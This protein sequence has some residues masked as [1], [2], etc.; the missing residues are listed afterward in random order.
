MR[1]TQFGRGLSLQ[2]LGRYADAVEDFD[3]AIIEGPVSWQRLWHRATCLSELDD[4]FR[5]SAVTDLWACL[6]MIEDEGLPEVS[7]LP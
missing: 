1:T 6:S 3:S 5:T 2:Q 7:I 4:S